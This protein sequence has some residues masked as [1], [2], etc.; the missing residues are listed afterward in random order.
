M[1]AE[2]PA[3]HPYHV[4]V[5][6]EA[7]VKGLQIRQDGTY[8]DCTLGG[9]GHARAIL[10][11]LGRSGRLFAF[12]QDIDAKANLP[13]DERALFIPQN[14]RHVQRF[15]RLHQVYQIDGLMADL[16]VSSHQLDEA[17]RGFST[18]FDADLDMRMDK[19]QDLTAF[20]I[21][22]NYNEAGLQ[23]LFEQNGELRNAKTLARTIVRARSLSE[24]RTVAQFKQAVDSA[25]L[26]N[27]HKWFAQVFQAIRIEVNDELG[28]LQEMLKQVP[29]L[30]VK[31]GRV[32]IISFHSIED[33]L[34]KQF[35]RQGIPEELTAD[36]FRQ[37]AFSSPFRIITKKPIVPS[38][39]E[40]KRNPRSA[41]AKLRVAEKE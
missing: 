14:F 35:F 26:G 13:N 41:S 30:L 11:R 37:Q 24:F 3:E 1:T 7:T 2:F 12:D 29:A 22:K 21:L 9:G 18:R 8:V 40:I 4:P 23:R 31:G 34:V 39:E 33:R 25:V 20:Y 16:G 17:A 36:P 15:L 32:V 10:E 5:L 28:A 38:A 27:P 6:L 19:R